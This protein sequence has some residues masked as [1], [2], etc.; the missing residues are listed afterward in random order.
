[1]KK[2]L[3]KVHYLLPLLIISLSISGCSSIKGPTT[4]KALG[5][6]PDKALVE[7]KWRLHTDETTHRSGHI[8][9]YGWVINNGSKRADWVRVTIYTIDK[10]TGVVVDKESVY[11]EGSGPN[12]KSLEP[13]KDA[14]F[15]FRL[16]SKKSDH[17]RYERDVTWAES[18]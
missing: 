18:Y 3:R 17:Y 15:K 6:T 13:G 2:A 16:N 11:I 4:N 14:M 7:F 10:K 9:V 8:K 5:A 12:G 1:M